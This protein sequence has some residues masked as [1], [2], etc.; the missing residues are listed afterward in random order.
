LDT[1]DVV[2]GVVTPSPAASVS[3]HVAAPLFDDRSQFEVRR[4]RGAADTLIH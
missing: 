3:A 4:F 2:T 1:V